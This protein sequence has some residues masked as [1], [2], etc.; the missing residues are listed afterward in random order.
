[1]SAGYSVEPVQRGN[2][3]A[4]MR[5]TVADHSGDR[6]DLTR[7][8]ADAPNATREMVNLLARRINSISPSIGATAAYRDPRPM[9]IPCRRNAMHDRRTT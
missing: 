3:L 7:A 2:L 4:E 5:K 1:M 6:G 8:P 9:M